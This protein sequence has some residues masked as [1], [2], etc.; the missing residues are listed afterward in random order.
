MGATLMVVA[1]GLASANSIIVLCT[2]ALTGHSTELNQTESCGGLPAGVLPSWIT[3]IQFEVSGSVDNPPSTISLTNNDTSSSHS[4]YAFTDSEFDVTGVPTGV[5]L[6]SDGLGNTFGVL[7]GTCAPLTSSCVSLTPGESEALNVSGGANT[8]LL[9]V[10]SSFGSWESPFSFLVTTNTSLTVQ[11]GGGNV[12][13]SQVTADNLSSEVIYDYTIPSGTPEPTT[14]A[15]MGGAL[16]GLGLI[17]KRFR[18]S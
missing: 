10:T 7:A 1:S 17:G 11:F 14:M 6:P 12:T 8:G 13:A 4:G 16:L 15:L 18:K 5:T 9:S 2:P 3:G